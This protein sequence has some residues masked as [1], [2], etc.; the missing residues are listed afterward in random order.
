MRS[1]PIPYHWQKHTLVTMNFPPFAL[2]LTI[3][4]A[5]RDVTTLAGSAAPPGPG[6]ADR[7]PRIDTMSAAVT[8]QGGVTTGCAA[9]AA[10]YLLQPN[11][12]LVSQVSEN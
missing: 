1:S 8:L 3:A 5:E 4:G 12:M 2:T 11:F 10:L 6:S 7:A 9:T